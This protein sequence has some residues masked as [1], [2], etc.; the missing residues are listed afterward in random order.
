MHYN[1]FI[2]DVKHVRSITS[3]QD[4]AYL[5]SKVI[6]FMKDNN[7]DFQTTFTNDHNRLGIINRVIKTLRDINNERD[8]TQQSMTKALNAYNNSVHSSINK[9][10]NDFTPEDE[11]QYIENKTLETNLKTNMFNI[12]NNSFVRIMNSSTPMKKKRLNLSD[13][14]YKVA[15][16]TG[17]K[18]VIK[19]L[20]NTAAEY[21]RYRLVVDSKA[22]PAQTL[23]TNRGIINEILGYKNNKYRVRYDNNSIDTLPIRNLR[24]GRPTRLSKL[25]LEYWKKHKSQIPNEIKALLQ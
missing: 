8:F 17:N 12:P 4:A 24:E 19:A 14:S 11:E 2:N 22:K 7:I 10:P 9:E 20:D 18:Y 21:P 15:Y 23:G 16:K 13:G 25:E 5:D 1:I 3:D 6:G